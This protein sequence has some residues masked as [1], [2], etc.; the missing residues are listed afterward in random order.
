MR[1]LGVAI[2]IIGM[3]QGCGEVNLIET[4]TQEEQLTIDLELIE[5]YRQK[6]ELTFVKDS[7][8]YPTQYVIIDEGDGEEIELNDIVFVHYVLKLTDG[9]VFDTSIDTV[10]ENNDIYVEQLTYEPRLFTH[11]ETGWAVTYLINNVNQTT[12]HEI[13]WRKGISA[14]LKKMKVGGH[15]II[16]VPSIYAYASTSPY[17]IPAN[18]PVIFEAYVVRAK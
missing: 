6:E 18:S 8:I 2:M 12:N 13:G 7:V 9:T 4:N 11:T 14:A 5:E 15:A 17:G 1:R 10:A 3:I 16:A